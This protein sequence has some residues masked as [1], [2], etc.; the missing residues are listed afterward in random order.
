VRVKICGVTT[1]EGARAAGALGADAVGFVLSESPRRV[2]PETARDLAALLPP[3]VVR[4]AVLREPTPSELE[5]VL[6]VFGPDVVQCEPAPEVERAIGSRARFLPVLHDAPDLLARAGG[7]TSYGGWLLEAPGRGG[8]GVAPD[9][10]RAAELA[11]R[12]PLVLAGGLDEDNVASAIRRVRPVA[13]DTSSGVE[14]APGIKDPRRIAGFIAAVRS[15]EAAS[16][17]EE[18]RR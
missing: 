15:A 10:E 12:G 2:S 6:S 7:A 16:G 18:E 4:V 17:F 1:P 3:F 8:R 9:W 13:V 14:T 5:R 11:R